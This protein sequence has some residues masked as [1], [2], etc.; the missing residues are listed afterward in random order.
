MQ[1]NRKESLVQA[2]VLAGFAFLLFNLLHTGKV[3]MFIN[4]RLT[5]LIEAAVILLGVFAI[6]K[7]I[8]ARKGHDHHHECCDHDHACGCGHEDHLP[9]T[10]NRNRA[11][12]FLVPLILGFLM[13]PRVLGSAVL[14]N[15]INASG[16]VP[17]YASPLSGSTRNGVNSSATI[18]SLTNSPTATSPATGATGESS[19]G[20]TGLTAP[21]DQASR[22]SLSQNAPDASGPVAGP[23]E[24]TDLV[25]LDIALYEN[26]EQLSGHRF[27]LTG[28]VYKDP[29]LENNQFVIARF[30][31]VCCLADT[32]PIGIIAESPNASDL[33]SDTWVEA[34]GVLKML[35]TFNAADTIE[36]V[37]NFH[38]ANTDIPDFV[39]TGLKKIPT[40]NDPYLYPP[41]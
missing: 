18:L 12:V 29:D 28:F 40:P 34:E 16:P 33:K 26:Q 24:D 2:M 30:V 7:L 13:Q 9:L 15:S 6:A 41:Q 4:P 3:V 36:P 39:I 35:S 38:G 1:A 17:F 11:V 22:N 5:W 27:R 25:Q 20:A 10:G 21:S 19:L 32:V 14:A 23:I 31:I 8:P 37:S